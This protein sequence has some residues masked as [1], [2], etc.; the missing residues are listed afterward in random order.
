M[1]SKLKISKHNRFKLTRCTLYAMVIMYMSLQHCHAST[2]THILTNTPHFLQ[3]VID[4]PHTHT[5]MCVHT[6]THTH[7]HTHATC[8]R[9]TSHTHTHTHTTHTHTHT[10]TTHKHTHTHT[11]HKHTL[12]PASVCRCSL[13]IVCRGVL[14]CSCPNQIPVDICECQLFDSFRFQPIPFLGDNI[15]R[16]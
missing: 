11:T 16:S 9:Y 14:F 7:T 3:L 1:E 4:T 5:H 10:H 2:L 6:H 13:C 15:S 12:A 8:E